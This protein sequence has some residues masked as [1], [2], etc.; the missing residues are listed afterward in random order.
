MA[1]VAF[2][3]EVDNRD[4]QSHCPGWI[5]THKAAVPSSAFLRFVHI[6]RRKWNEI[7]G[8]LFRSKGILN[9]SLFEES[10]HVEPF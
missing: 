9:S 1:L 5:F 6:E 10:V 8:G 4:V 7:R 3:N 2:V